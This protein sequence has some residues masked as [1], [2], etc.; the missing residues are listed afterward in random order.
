M[1]AEYIFRLSCVQITVQKKSAMIR[2]VFLLLDGM[3]RMGF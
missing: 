1:H 2:F 3:T